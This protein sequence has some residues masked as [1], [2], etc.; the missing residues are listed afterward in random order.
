[1][2]ANEVSIS[3][4][5]DILI[6]ENEVSIDLMTDDSIEETSDANNYDAG[7]ILRIEGNATERFGGVRSCGDSDVHQAAAKR[8]LNEWAKNQI[9]EHRN[10]KYTRFGHLGGTAQWTNYTYWDGRRGCSGHVSIKCFIE[11]RKP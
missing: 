7:K 2:D 11:F 9:F 3:G 8:A 6:I 4:N 5:N 10:L 1:M